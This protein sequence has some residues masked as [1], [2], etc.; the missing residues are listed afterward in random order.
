MELSESAARILWSAERLSTE[1]MFSSISMSLNVAE[2]R[3]LTQDAVEKARGDLSVVLLDHVSRHAEA[4]P[5]DDGA[6]VLTG[7]AIELTRAQ[8]RLQTAALA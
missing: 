2:G 4:L 3:K 8:K 6:A 7:A 1:A 5:R